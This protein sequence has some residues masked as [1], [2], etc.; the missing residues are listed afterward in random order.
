M[1]EHKQPKDAVAIL[2][3]GIEVD[4]ENASLYNDLGNAFDDLGNKDRAIR[5]YKKAISISPRYI[6][7]YINLGIVSKSL[8]KKST[9]VNA[10]GEA[11]KIDPSNQIV[12]HHLSALTGITENTAP[13]KYITELFDAY[14]PD[15]E[16]SLVNLLD[17]R[18]PDIVTEVLLKTSKIS[19]LL[20]F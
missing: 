3:K 12:Q 19:K 15:F 2:L 7:A 11:L 8:G 10:F 20:R 6:E 1:R 4:T 16:D 9:A 18:L 5:S 14:A 17:Y 13:R